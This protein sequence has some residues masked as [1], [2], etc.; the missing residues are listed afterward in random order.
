MCNSGVAIPRSM[1]VIAACVYRSPQ[2]TLSNV[3]STGTGP[4]ASKN[5][6]DADSTL[7]D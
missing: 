7:R 1:R 4:E 3:A 2:P 5:P 6:A